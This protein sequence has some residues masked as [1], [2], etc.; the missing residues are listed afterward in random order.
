MN[1]R[2]RNPTSVF[3]EAGLNELGHRPTGQGGVE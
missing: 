2:E 1:Y 3:R